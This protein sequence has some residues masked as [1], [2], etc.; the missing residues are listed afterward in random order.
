MAAH[1]GALAIGSARRQSQLVRLLAGMERWPAVAVWS[2]T[3]LG[4]E[5]TGV[6]LVSLWAVIT[7]RG[8]GG[9]CRGAARILRTA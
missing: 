9:F 1:C 3:L 8:C 7:R 6:S 5:G 4:P 2:S